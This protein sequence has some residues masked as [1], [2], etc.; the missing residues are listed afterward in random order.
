MDYEKHLRMVTTY[1]SR[2]CA[3]G[4]FWE[5]LA[6]E[7]NGSDRVLHQARE[8]NTFIENPGTHRSAIHTD[9]KAV[10]TSVLSSKKQNRFRKFPLWG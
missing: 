1:N 9:S 10:A 3:L 8:G 6:E 7:G 5:D 4:M 2:A